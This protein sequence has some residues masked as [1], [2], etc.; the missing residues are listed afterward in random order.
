MRVALTGGIGAGKSYVCRALERRGINVY[1]CDA[2]AK[3]LMSSSADMKQKLSQLVGEEVFVDGVLRKQLL[4][5]F[6]TA[7]EVNAR[8][9]NDIVHPAVATDF[10]RSGM[11]WLESAI[12]FDSGFCRRVRVDCVVCVAAPEEVRI[13][14]VMRRDGIS[15]EKALAWIR[16]QLPQETIISQ[17]TYVIVNDGILDI[18]EQIDKII[19]QINKQ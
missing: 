7:D 15:R 2:A 1:D 12:F 9:V 11:Q 14:R 16:R 19:K 10:E 5:R 4:A 18:E 3:R 6:I 8:A 13:A 17:S